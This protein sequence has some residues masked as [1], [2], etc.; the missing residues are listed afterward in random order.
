M[1][2][3]NVQPCGEGRS[4]RERGIDSLRGVH[5]LVV[6]DDPDARELLSM[7]LGHWGALVTVA[8]SAREALAMLEPSLPDVLV[9]DISMPGFDGC[10]LIRQIR[11][12]P[13]ELGGALPAVAV[14]ALGGDY[15]SERAQAAGFQA[16]L[17]KPVDA[18]RL[19]RVV[20]DLVRRTD[21]Q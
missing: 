4:A 17:R 9:S 16:Y 20:S 10:W 3:Q 13:A 2:L 18:G 12:R 6:D 14:T 7:L 1:A 21:A 19:A 8:A 11:A 5:V 15:G